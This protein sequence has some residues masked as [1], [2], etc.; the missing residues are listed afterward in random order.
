MTWRHL[1]PAAAPVLTADL[2]AGVTGAAQSSAALRMFEEGFADAHGVTRAWGVSSGRA[3]LTVALRA[4]RQLS[5]RT[6]VV[7]PAFTCFSVPAAIVRAGLDVVGCD[8]EPGTLDFDQ[9]QLTNVLERERPLAVV[10][11][12]L[13][14]LPC[15]ME[16]LKALCD[17]YGAYVI[18]DAAQALGTT[19]DGRPAGTAGHIG[20]YSF[21]RGKSVTC[22]SGGAI[23][24][25][26]PDIVAAIE[27]QVAALEE[28]GSLQ[29]ASA[30]AEAA[31]LAVFLR[32]SLYRIP[33]SVPGLHLGETIYSVDFAVRR[34]SGAQAGLLKH[35]RVRLTE[36][37]DA[38]RD[39]VSYFRRAA[40][41]LVPSRAH[42]CIRLPI[43]CESREARDW[44]VSVGREQR[45]GISL[46]YPT[47]VNG[48]SELRGTLGL[49]VFPNAERVAERLL[50]VPVHPWMTPRDRER[51][52]QLLLNQLA[53]GTKPVTPHAHVTP[54]R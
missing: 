42:T 1:P 39:N 4:L 13:F 48:I 10:A 5:P 8:I 27:R 26:S 43:I 21:G 31:V 12:H 51:V 49:Q 52:G 25:S 38:R 24:A 44:L 36:W 20:F 7:I 11:T 45:L 50:T 34:M 6:S 54:S 9:G 18:D 41:A 35:W 17:R 23:V 22:G 53:T 33:A 14:G 46:M 37:N 2:V 19:V 30:L 40:P 47:A 16:R 32:P 15:S 3:A 29:A 28:P